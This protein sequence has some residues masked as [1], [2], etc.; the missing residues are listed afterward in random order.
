MMNSYDEI[1][2]LVNE[3]PCHKWYELAILL[4]HNR[5]SSIATIQVQNEVRLIVRR[6]SSPIYRSVTGRMRAL[7]DK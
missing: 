4:N 2:N 3:K 6:I 7:N 5:N 1:Y